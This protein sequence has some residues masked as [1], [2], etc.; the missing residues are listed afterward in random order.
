MHLPPEIE[1]KI[2]DKVEAY[3][4]VEQVLI[5][6]LEALDNQEQLAYEREAVLEGIQQLEN[7]QSTQYTT[8]ELD[9]VFTQIKAN[10]RRKLGV[11]RT[12]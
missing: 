6:A 1:Q 12:R 9:K 11:E 4:S 3:G 5:A 2:A 10:G 7:G 8:D